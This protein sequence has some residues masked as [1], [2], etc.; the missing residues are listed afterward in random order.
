MPVKTIAM[1]RLEGKK[2]TF[3]MDE[4]GPYR[5][6]YV[7]FYPAELVEKIITDLSNQVLEERKKWTSMFDHFKAKRKELRDARHE[8]QDAL[9]KLRLAFAK[10]QYAL[11][12]WITEHCRDA[13]EADNALKRLRFWTRARNSL[14]YKEM[15]RNQRKAA[16]NVKEKV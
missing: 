7:D 8:V 5:H 9:H 12:F 16:H 13:N 1:K 4:H 3:Y 15:F 14:S 2:R 11:F 6:E 10:S